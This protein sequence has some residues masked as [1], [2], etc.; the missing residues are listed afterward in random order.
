MKGNLSRIPSAGYATPLDIV[1]IYR[2]QT[3]TVLMN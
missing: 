2:D 1:G 3:H